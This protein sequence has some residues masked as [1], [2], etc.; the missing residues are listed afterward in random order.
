M[1]GG[2]ASILSLGN[3]ST[4]EKSQCQTASREKKTPCKVKICTKLSLCPA[5]SVKK[6]SAVKALKSLPTVNTSRCTL[7]RQ[8]WDVTHS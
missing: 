3:T 4:K 5:E 7:W 2:R 6:N 1:D 8:S